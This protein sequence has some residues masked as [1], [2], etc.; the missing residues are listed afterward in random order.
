MILLFESL[1][2]CICVYVYIYMHTYIHDISGCMHIR[3]YLHPY[4]QTCTHIHAYTRMY[5]H[6][7]THLLQL[8]KAQAS[9]G[10]QVCALVGKPCTRVCPK[11]L[12]SPHPCMQTCVCG[13]VCGWVYVYPHP[14]MHICVWVCRCMHLYVYACVRVCTHAHAIRGHR[15]LAP[16]RITSKRRF[17]GFVAEYAGTPPAHATSDTRAPASSSASLPSEWL[18]AGRPAVSKMSSA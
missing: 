12:H 5:L 7:H 3:M 15:W 2:E 10:N 4:M 8:T 1:H 18:W 14:C 6:I 9:G 11:T 13:W 17:C 16:T